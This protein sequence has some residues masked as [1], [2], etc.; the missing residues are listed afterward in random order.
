MVD[1][2]VQIEFE[3]VELREQCE[4]GVG[5]SEMD[6]KSWWGPTAKLVPAFAI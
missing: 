6:S 2:E 1:F 4:N 5:E 3:H